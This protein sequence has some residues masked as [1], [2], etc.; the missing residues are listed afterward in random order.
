MLD[1]VSIDK[2]KAYRFNAFLIFKE[3]IILWFKGSFGLVVV[4]TPASSVLLYWVIPPLS[5]DRIMYEIVGQ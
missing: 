4:L 3:Q 1:Y 5:L 2:N